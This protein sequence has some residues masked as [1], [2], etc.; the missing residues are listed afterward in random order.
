MG[1]PF[2]GSR[3]E[4]PLFLRSSCWSSVEESEEEVVSEESEEHVT[5]NK[6][7]KVSEHRPNSDF[8]IVRDE[9]P[10]QGYRCLIW[11]RNLHCVT[12]FER[13]WV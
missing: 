1:L 3:R 13:P 6:G 2:I 8:G 4:A 12:R 10:K 9:R 7:G 11:T 5:V